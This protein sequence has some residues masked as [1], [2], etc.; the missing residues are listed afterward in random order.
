MDGLLVI[1]K[2]VGPTSHDVVRR[3]RRAIGE[4][5]VGHTG[6]LDPGA[7]GV[8]PLVL[9]RAT[10]LARFLS[11]SDKAY[12]AIIRLGV[13]TDTYDSAG[14]PVGHPYAGRMPAREEIDRA[15]DPF[16]GTFAQ[17]PPAYSAKKVAGVR[18]YKLARR[19]RLRPCE[20]EAGQSRPFDKLRVVL[21]RVE[22]RERASALVR[23]GG[24]PPSL[25]F[26]ASAVART[27][28]ERAEA[29]A[30]A[31]L[32]KK[33]VTAT[34]EV[35]NYSGDVLA[36]RVDC[37]AGFYVR[38]LAHDLGERLGTGAHLVA[39]RRTR[40]G[41]LTL[42]D[43]IPLETLERDAEAVRAALVPP[44]RMLPALAAVRLTDEGARRVRHGR[45]LGPADV[46]E[47]LA[48]GPPSGHVAACA[49]LAHAGK[50][51][52]LLDQ[53]GDLVGVAEPAATQGLLHP[54]VV[55]V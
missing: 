17:Q 18:S 55:L 3:V 23:A 53:S 51:I 42:A 10:R 11:A 33:F 40:S 54:A 47:H 48:A 36:L 9:G 30:P 8:L 1:D 20:L 19:E 13:E 45:D 43:T 26:G 49:P 50:Y 39:L 4:R 15:L 7:S 35:L 41:E 29:E 28:G 6:T 24:G 37:S 46:A 21:S 52:R 5:R 32:E 12:E 14:E 2:P 31:P 34:V 22:G 25:G 38:S 44:G 16:R 27:L